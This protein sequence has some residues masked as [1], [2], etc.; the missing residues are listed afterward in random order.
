MQHDEIVALCRFVREKLEKIRFENRTI[1]FG[2][3][4]SFPAGCCKIT[5]FI[6]MYYLSNIKRVPKGDLVLL[7]NAKICSGSH[8]WF[9]YK[10]LHIDLTGDQFKPFNKPKIIVQE[11][12]PWPDSNYST[13]P[14]EM[15][16]FNSQYEDKLK[17]VCEYLMSE[18]SA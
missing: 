11:Q 18:L 14:F 4:K 15:Q 10:N 17:E 13:H 9:K 16:E 5:S 6:M 2:S 8:A 12:D 7:A 1:G 3:L